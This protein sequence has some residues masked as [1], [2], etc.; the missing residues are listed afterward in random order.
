MD[1]DHL[2]LIK[3]LGYVPVGLGSKQFNSHWMQDKSK[4]NISK[5]NSFYGEYTFHYWLWKNYLDKIDEDW[6]GF[7]QY[8][9]FFFNQNNI[10][11]SLTFKQIKNHCVKEIESQKNNFECILGEKFSVENYKIMKVIKNYPLEFLINP[12]KIFFKKKRTIKFQFDLYHGKGN[13]DEAINLLDEKNREKFKKFVNTETSFNP[14]NMFI[15]KKEILE[16]YYESIF[17][18]LKNCEK[19]FG[20]KN[21]KGYGMTRIYGFLAERYLSYWFSENYKVKEL[22][23]VIKDISDY[24]NL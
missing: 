23:I 20:F 5:K 9:K 13:L 8:R 3:D 14:H 22:P 10:E 2:D 18:W 7:C 4:N 1:P 21:L 16:K 11:N 6:I 15:C 12:K 17:P 24:K 19:V